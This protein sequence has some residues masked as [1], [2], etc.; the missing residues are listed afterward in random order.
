[1][2]TMQKKKQQLQSIMACQLRALIDPIQQP[3]HIYATP[4]LTRGISTAPI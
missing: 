1:L 3:T 4:S 2:V